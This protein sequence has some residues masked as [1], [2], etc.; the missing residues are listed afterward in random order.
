MPNKFC[1]DTIPVQLPCPDFEVLY[2]GK[3]LTAEVIKDINPIEDQILLFQLSLTEPKKVK[4]SLQN[5]IL[6]IDESKLFFVINEISPRSITTYK[7]DV[8]LLTVHWPP[9]FPLVKGSMILFKCKYSYKVKDV[10][11]ES[12]EITKE[13]F[14]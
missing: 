8:I 13:I 4:D 3:P 7:P 10:I 5:L 9:K 11:I 14:F 2:L 12:G 6:T 1:A